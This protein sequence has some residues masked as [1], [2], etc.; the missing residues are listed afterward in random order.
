M[1]EACE[2]AR[3]VVEEFPEP[4]KGVSKREAIFSEYHRFHDKYSWEEEGELVPQLSMLSKEEFKQY[5]MAEQAI[6]AL[7]ILNFVEEMKEKEPDFTKLEPGFLGSRM[8]II[9]MWHAQIMGIDV[10]LDP[11]IMNK[12]RALLHGEII[13][14]SRW[15]QRNKP[16]RDALEL[17][18]KLWSTGDTRM[19]HEMVAFLMEQIEEFRTIKDADEWQN[20]KRRLLKEIGRLAK[21]KYPERFFFPGNSKSDNP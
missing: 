21:T 4:A 1:N 7:Q 14:N 8:Y 12:S 15:A 19:H 5:F 6:W 13:K 18:D 11:A 16:F 10:M 9:G 20:N 2:L 17:A 3:A